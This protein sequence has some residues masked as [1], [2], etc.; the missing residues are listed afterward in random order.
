MA[1]VTSCVQLL[2]PGPKVTEKEQC[3]DWWLRG[4]NEAT[5]HDSQVQRTLGKSDQPLAWGFGVLMTNVC[6]C[7]VYLSVWVVHVWVVCVCVTHARAHSPF[8]LLRGLGGSLKPRRESAK[9]I[10]GE[11]DFA[12]MEL[13]SLWRSFLDSFSHVSPSI[14]SCRSSK[15][16][17]FQTVCLL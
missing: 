15:E 16:L 14:S 3:A 13:F 10:Q 9:R 1:V 11:P 2:V 17:R 7:S 6:V 8:S 5:P 4:V 12:M